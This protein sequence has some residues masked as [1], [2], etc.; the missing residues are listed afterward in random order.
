M[1]KVKKY[2]RHILVLFLAFATALTCMFIMAP[3]SE[4]AAGDY[5]VR[6]VS[7]TSTYCNNIDSSSVTVTYVSNNGTGSSTNATGSVDTSLYN[8]DNEGS[9]K[10]LYS[11][12][13]SGFP[14]Y[15][16]VKQTVRGNAATRKYEG[17]FYL[18]VYSTRE[19]A[20]KT[21]A[22]FNMEWSKLS[23]SEHSHDGSA[24]VSIPD[25]Y[26]YVYNW[27]YSYS[28]ETPVTIDAEGNSVTSTV[29]VAPVDQYGISW[30]TTPTYSSTNATLGNTSSLSP[31]L[32]FKNAASDYTA[33][34]DASLTTANTSHSSCTLSGSLNATPSV[35]VKVPRS[36]TFD[37]LY[38][39]NAWRNSG[40]SGSNGT[41]SN[42]TSTGFTLTS[43]SGVS[44]GTAT[45]IEFTNVQA[46]KQYK[47]F[48]DTEG[49]GWDA[50]VFFRDSSGTWL[51]TD[52][53]SR[54]SDSD[55]S[56]YPENM[57]LTA[58]TGTVKAALRFDANGSSNTVK[59]SNIRLVEVGTVAAETT[60]A[61]PGVS[62]SYNDAFTTVAPSLPY[63][64]GY[65]F[66]GWYDAATG[67]NLY[68]NAS[69]TMTKTGVCT[70]D[71]ALFS[72][73]TANV[74]NIAFDENGG[75]TVTDI[76]STDITKTVSIPT[77]T[78]TG[79]T[80]A[81]WEVVTT[82]VDTNWSGTY[83]A[84]DYTKM[85]G[86]NGGT[87][88]LKAKWT[89]IEYTITYNVNGGT[90]IEALTYT[91]EDELNIP[92]A[93][94]TG[95][96][97]NH[98]TVTG[99]TGNWTATT[100]APG[101]FTNMY[102]NVTLNADYTINKYTVKWL[103]DDGK[104][105]ETDL[106]VPY[107]TMVSYDGTEPSKAAT[108][109]YTYTW[110]GWDKELA[111][112]EGDVT[113]TAVYE[114]TVNEYTVTWMNG[115]SIIE[116][117]ENVPYG[118]MPSYDGATPEKTATDRYTYTFSGWDK[119][120][121]EVTGNVTYTAQFDA[122]IN[123]YYVYWVNE[124]GSELE[125][126]YVEHGTDPSYDGAEPE[127]A[128]DAQYTYFFK[129]WS[130]AI[131]MVSG[132]IT[133][134]A[135]YDKSVNRYK[136]TFVDE[137][138]TT[139][140]DEQ[141]L[142]YGAM[143]V[144]GGVTPTKDAT[145]EYT[146]TFAGWDKE[147]SSVTGE[148]TYKATYS[149]EKN[150]YT[151]TWYDEDGT[152]VLDEQV[153]EYGSTITYGGETPSKTE[154]G[155]TW[156]FEGWDN[157]V[158]TVTGDTSF[159]ATYSYT[160]NLWTVTWIVDGTTHSITN[161]VKY[162][163]ALSTI[164]PKLEDTADGKVG[165]WI[166]D[167]YITMPDHDIEMH[168]HYS[169]S[170]ISWIVDG[171]T[172]KSTAYD[173]GA[174]VTGPADPTKAATA[175]YTYVF[176]YWEGS[177]G[178]Q[179]KSGE[180]FPAAT[181][182]NVTYTAVF[183]SFLNTYQ[184]SFVDEDGETIHSG[185]IEYGTELDY[186]GEEPSKKATAQYTY[187]FAGWSDGTNVYASDE[188]PAITGNVTYKATF[189]QTV[190]KY[191]ITWVDEDGAELDKQT[192]EYGSTPKYAGEAPAKEATEQYEYTF[193]GWSPAM[194]TVTGNKTYKAVYTEAVRKY[195]VTWM[196]GGLTLLVDNV[197]YGTK[198]E[199]TGA[200]PTKAPTDLVAYEFIGWDKEI[201]E[202]TGAVTYYAQF[203]EVDREFYV[204]FYV[205]GV[206]VATATTTFGQNMKEFLVDYP[207]PEKEGYTGFWTIVPETMPAMDITLEAVYNPKSYEVTINEDK[208]VTEK[209]AVFGEDFSYVF[210]GEAIPTG[211]RVTVNGATISSTNYVYNALTG[212]LTIY[213]SAIKGVIVV[214]AR[215][216]GGTI[217]V[218]VNI[219]NGSATNTAE[220]TAERT[221]YHT[222]IVP[223][224]GYLLPKEIKVYVDGAYVADGYTYDSKTG[225]L[226][227]NAEI[228]VGSLEI[229]TE[230]PVDPNYD[231]DSSTDTD[232]EDTTDE[233]TCS[234]HSESGFVRFFFKII[235]F[236]RMI[237]G[238]DEYRF[239]DCGAAHW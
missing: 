215:Y 41:V 224:E 73:W 68:A 189:T 3:Q 196:N 96:T 175:Q 161:N 169:D 154:V 207:V 5:Q 144:Y 221:A 126:D 205:D 204:Y 128:A 98:W 100:V 62:I 232:T 212:E 188:I 156:T 211:V 47:L 217:D 36:I 40:I 147:I 32:T 94:K 195:R 72:Q 35:E 115:N 13:L 116:T 236:L 134:T 10:V 117:D 110:T 185:L 225:K 170:V 206:N 187:T 7:N 135:T 139:V 21:V 109:Q 214:T 125:T 86:P 59:F 22:S 121:S 34:W 50:Y 150:K 213:G 237:F 146:Y 172:V 133:Y 15:F 210:T 85:Y 95:Y 6:I 112:V 70:S 18:Q 132:N 235:C 78:R 159:K 118:T 20:W 33:S 167:D 63:R 199:Y 12:T 106:N 239:C 137:D 1:S 57:I 219:Y 2:S 238:M 131:S 11:A 8:E 233:C 99:N 76:A 155:K 81:G 208:G 223:A 123:K 111:K 82:G 97:F 178:V 166:Y 136:V 220:S 92:A 200:T 4:A 84:G 101:T 51:G 229:F 129:G 88:T 19:S 177:N 48:V 66:T 209:T 151:V 183:N 227:V 69:A 14:S 138:G 198:P 148:A 58:P 142:D 74:Y 194:E 45:S 87:I 54:V 158:T 113:Y 29:T 77:T 191:T 197:E 122:T 218:I 89:P 184:I 75:A 168:A 46:G 141:T 104:T 28:G 124:D 103:D 27:N 130:P 43:N 186:P 105:L 64:A 42:I 53:T 93:D 202:V 107:G 16:Y 203:K 176:A 60:V 180:A 67:G 222:Q 120:V 152:T 52:G 114:A 127:K 216:T 190:N 108:A 182:E 90:A 9:D 79:Y 31:S 173:N 80:F 83:Q 143:P 91:I 149:A 179:I 157:D 38:N 181:T 102:G 226:T 140:L 231:P 119:E 164:A 145:T 25:H 163:T 162:G 37:N 17:N 49:S 174:S 24:T 192:L 165:A 230:C 193:S 23:W 201:T 44:E 171:V 61:K 153:L 39:Y 71:V 234:C 56:H 65:T 26:P 55:A 30:V 228:V 160:D